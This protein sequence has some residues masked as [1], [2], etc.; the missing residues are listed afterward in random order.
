MVERELGEMEGCVMSRNSINSDSRK[1]PQNERDGFCPFR[2]PPKLV[3]AL[4]ISR[5]DD[6]KSAEWK[7]EE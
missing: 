4:T 6:E 5:S 2:K 3:T 1:G 7:E